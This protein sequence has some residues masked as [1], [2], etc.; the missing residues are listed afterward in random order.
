MVYGRYNYSIHGVYKPTY[1]WGAPPCIARNLR[2]QVS[3]SPEIRFAGGSR[4]SLAAICAG[5]AKD[6]GVP[7]RK[8]VPWL[9]NRESG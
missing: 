1:N 7:R 9:D 2:F 6:P 3:R 4:G 5:E 8:D